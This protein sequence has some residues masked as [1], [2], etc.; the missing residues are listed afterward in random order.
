MTELH[1]KTLSSLLSNPKITILD[2]TKGEKAVEMAELLF[3]YN[4]GCKSAKEWSSRWN[5]KNKKESTL[6]VYTYSPRTKKQFRF[7]FIIGDD[8]GGERYITEKRKK[9]FWDLYHTNPMDYWE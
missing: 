6:I 9:L 3:F 2:I 5:V 7:K 8:I 4:K 1:S